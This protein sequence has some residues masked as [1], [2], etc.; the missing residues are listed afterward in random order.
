MGLL[1]VKLGIASVIKNF[2]LTPGPEMKFPI[3][4]APEKTTLEPPGG[5]MLKFER[6]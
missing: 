2:K 6:V 1:N 4:L 3:K 5:F